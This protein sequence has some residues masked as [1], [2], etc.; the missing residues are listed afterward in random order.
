MRLAPGFLVGGAF[1]LLSG[2]AGPCRAETVV[3]L[4]GRISTE[5]GWGRAVWFGDRDG[6]VRLGAVLSAEALFLSLDVA[7]DARRDARVEVRLG[8][9]PAV[10]VWPRTPA[11]GGAAGAESAWRDVLE[12]RVPWDLLGT[13]GPSNLRVRLEMHGRSWRYPRSGAI[14][15]E[16]AG[17]PGF[18]LWGFWSDPEGDVRMPAVPPASTPM[19][20]ST[21][22]SA[23]GL[24]EPIASQEAEPSTRPSRWDLVSCQLLG[25]SRGEVRLKLKFAQP[26]DGST[27]PV[28]QVYWDT[29][30]G[31]RGDCLRG[32]PAGLAGSSSWEVAVDVEGNGARLYSGG[33]T[34]DVPGAARWNVA[35]DEMEIALPRGTLP[36]RPRGMLVIV[37]DA[38]A[39]ARG[40][41]DA[42]SDIL[43]P[44][45]AI[46]AELPMPENP[47][48]HGDVSMSRPRGASPATAR[49]A[50]L[51][52]P[53]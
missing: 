2:S 48:L 12:A 14:Q 1:L 49:L 34:R 16:P 51:P 23:G 19:A 31:G 52:V 10:T 42:V 24:S 32:V 35:G 44:A 20:S 6:P 37:L 46:Q 28:V 40:D 43:D 15:V 11:V 17:A 39:L 3:R 41:P 22:P 33:D 21:T 30:P 36:V 9:G 4:D 13:V 50:A 5:E 7:G 29:K 18:R 27:A 38:P 26:P 47:P 25:S 53:K 8:S 45:G